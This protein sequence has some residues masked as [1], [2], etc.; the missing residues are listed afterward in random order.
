MHDDNKRFGTRCIHAGQQPDPS[1]GAIMTPVYQTSTFVQQSPG[2]IIED[3]DYARSANPTRKALEANLA[4]L[5][6]GRHGFNFASGLAAQAAC[7]HLLASGDHVVLSDDVY[8][9]TYRQFDKVFKQF[10]ITYTR[11]DLTDLAKAEEAFKS[12]TKMVWLETPTNPLLKVIDIAA[13]A[14]LAKSKNALTIVDNT[15]ATP[16]LT[17]PLALGADIVSHSCTKYIGGHS[18]VIGGALICRDDALAERLR[19]TQNANGAIAAPWDSFL[20]LRS[21]KT[22]HVRVQRHCENAAKIADFLAEQKQIERVVYPGR[23][24][25]PQHDIAKKQMT[26]GFGGMITAY[27]KGGLDPARTFLERVKLFSLAESLGGVESLI[28]HPAIMTHASVD[29]HLREQ[30]GLTDGL[31]RFSVGIEDVEDLISDIQEA[32]V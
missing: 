19:F 18:D 4:S 16:V 31:V 17:N 20:L 29:K 9:G 14:R 21:T 32:L 1:T 10:G 25:H 7:I 5:E 23:T 28:E 30:I 11:A 8:G 3:Y 15:F 12:N 22:L 27:F 6:G 13:V 26:G 2:V 24:D